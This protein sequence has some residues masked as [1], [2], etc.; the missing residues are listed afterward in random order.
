MV[1]HLQCR[2]REARL[3]NGLTQEDLGKAVGVTRQTI[4][5]VEKQKFVPS[6][7]LA[8]ELAR[9]LRVPLDDLFWLSDARGRAL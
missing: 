8:L 3:T 9:V 7:R 6:V 4:I 5:A 1:A 2:L